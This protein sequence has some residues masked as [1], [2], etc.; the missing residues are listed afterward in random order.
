MWD[1]IPRRLLGT[2]SHLLRIYLQ[3]DT[4]IVYL[5]M[6]ISRHWGDI[7]STILNAKK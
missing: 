5:M 3:P 7:T 2:W 1:I 6:T 4:L